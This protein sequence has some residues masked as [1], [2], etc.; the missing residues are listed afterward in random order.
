MELNQ[1]SLKR[2]LLAGMQL[3]I[4]LLIVFGKWLGYDI[5]ISAGSATLLKVGS[6][7]KRIATNICSNGGGGLMFIAVLI[8]LLLVIGASMTWRT[9]SNLFRSKTVSIAGICSAS[10]CLPVCS[11]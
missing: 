2:W 9:V 8:Y 7:M 4:I 1:W 5:Y 10:F 3:V 11:C 6:L